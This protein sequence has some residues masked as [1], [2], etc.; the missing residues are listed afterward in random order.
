MN[1]FLFNVGF[2]ADKITCYLFP[3][4][5]ISAISVGVGHLDIDVVE[6]F[7]R[8]KLIGHRCLRVNK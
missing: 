5:N 6:H 7:C 4:I 2:F 3:C 8:F 1:K